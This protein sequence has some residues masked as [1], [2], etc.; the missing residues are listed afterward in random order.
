VRRALA[1]ILCAIALAPG[2]AVGPDY[3]RPELPAP[4]EYRD[5]PAQTESLAD[6]AWWE[7]FEDEALAALIREALENNRDLA[8]ATTNVETARYLAAVTRGELFPQVGYEGSGS[9]GDQSVLGA[10]AP[11]SVTTD[12]F[13]AVANLAWEIDVWGRIRRATEGARAQLLATEAFRRGVQL[14]VVTGVAQAYLELR[15]LDLELEIAYANVKSFQD[16]YDLFQRRYSGGVASK[17]DPL[18]ADA[19]LA[20]AQAAVPVIQASIVAKENEISVLL[21]RPAATVPRGAALTAQSFPPEI[22]VGVPSTLL[23]RRPDLIQVEQQ[24]VASNARIGEAFAGFF[25]RIGLTAFGGA[26]SQEASQ[27]LDAGN[28]AWSLSGSALGPLFTAGRTT[29]TWRAAQSARDADVASYQNQV[30]IALKEVSDALTARQRLAES[31]VLQEREVASLREAVDVATTRYTGGLANYYEV[32]DAQQQLFPAE[33][34][35]ARTQRDELLAVV[36]LYRALGG[37]WSQE[38]PLDPS[39]PTPLAF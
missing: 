38:R 32:L 33:I 17:L 30:L 26:I 3:A 11:G 22:P 28:G 18:R 35:L 23:E 1:L 16:T 24:L 12:S 25:P 10:P 6:V 15:E 27:L 34:R 13:L 37:G 29:Y 31:R 9:R 2:C 20:Q 21:G 14:S 36:A 5:Q 19:A 39:L 8:L 4:P 7:L